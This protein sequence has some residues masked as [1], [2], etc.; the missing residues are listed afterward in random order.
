MPSI[1]SASATT[2]HPSSRPSTSTLPES[3]V[4]SCGTLVSSVLNTPLQSSEAGPLSIATGGLIGAMASY[5]AQCWNPLAS[6][7]AGAAVGAVLGR[8]SLEASRHGQRKEEAHRQRWEFLQSHRGTRQ[9]LENYGI[10]FGQRAAVRHVY[11]HLQKLCADMLAGLRAHCRDCDV[12][13]SALVEE[14]LVH[15]YVAHCAEHIPVVVSR[16]AENRYFIGAIKE[17][18]ADRV[19]DRM[20]DAKDPAAVFVDEGAMHMVLE[21]QAA[22]RFRA[23]VFD[24]VACS[25]AGAAGRRPAGFPD[26]RP[27]VVQ[28]RPG[29]AIASL[30]ECRPQPVVELR[31]RSHSQRAARAAHEPA[32]APAHQRRIRETVTVPVVLG[33]MLQRQCAHL[34]EGS[35]TLTDIG[36]IMEDLAQGRTTRHSVTVDGERYIARDIHLDGLS[37]RNRW[38][39]LHRRTSSGY[40]LV[41]IADYHADARP[42]HWWNS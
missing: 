15:F 34:D 41:G 16:L 32:S 10:R 13:S 37:G 33:K 4:F 24:P 39:L 1:V 19:R 31:R 28:S 14:V 20:I 9:M 6:L 18:A 12:P 11:D 3:S 22:G 25:R 21:L 35:R 23:R 27:I 42:A 40:E 8:G 5:V 7:T 26:L 38:R 17:D 2:A 29:E 36:S 30:P